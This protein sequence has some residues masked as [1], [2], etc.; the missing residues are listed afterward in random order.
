MV[1]SST[2]VYF[3]CVLLTSGCR[4]YSQKWHIHQFACAQCVDYCV[5]CGQI[6]CPRFGCVCLHFRR[7]KL[8]HYDHNLMVITYA[9][10][11]FSNSLKKS[12]RYVLWGDSR[13]MK[14]RDE[15]STDIHLRPANQSYLVLKILSNAFQE[16]IYEH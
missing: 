12:N 14:L 3:P 7:C 6:L 8:H 15:I 5:V 13:R 2:G 4:I 11:D 1:V 10:F 16:N 9:I